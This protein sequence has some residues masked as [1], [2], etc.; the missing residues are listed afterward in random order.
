MATHWLR[1]INTTA[2]GGNGTPF[3]VKALAMFLR[4]V[5]GYTNQSQVIL[6]TGTGDSVSAPAGPDFQTLTDSFGSFLSTDVGKTITISG[7]VDPNNNG[8]FTIASYISATQITYQNAAGSAETSSF[9]WAITSTDEDYWTF[10]KSGSNGSINI[11]GSDKRFQDTT[12]A[13][14]VAGDDGK[15]ILIQDSTNSENSGWY[16]VTFVDASNVDLDFRSGAAEYPTQNLGANL[17]WWLMSDSYE[18]PLRPRCYWRLQTPHATGWEI[19]VLYDNPSTYQKLEIRL[20]PGAAWGGS[21]ILTTVHTGLPDGSAAWF[22]CAADDTGDFINFVFHNST[23]NYYGG[24][25]AGNLTEYEPDRAAVELVAL[26]GNSNSS[27]TAWGNSTTY[28]RGLIDGTNLTEGSIWENRLAKVQTCYMLEPSYYNSDLGLTKWTSGQI[29]QR[30][31]N[32]DF[33]EGQPIIID[34]D[35][36]QPIGEY[37][38]AGNLAGM[39]LMPNQATVRTAYDDVGTRDRFH[40]NDGVAIE[41]P[42]YTAQH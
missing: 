26:M 42:G 32:W 37:E 39:F 7:M 4:F 23:S 2:T 3:A 35:N 9:S 13:S 33:L 27:T 19:E 24:F 10:E 8:A 38:I 41:W 30:T 18:V 21:Q 15:W 5:C 6:N 17:S 1:E 11:T 40:I 25:V 22:Y 29:N 12:A 16:K 20:A 14:F 31:G 34:P 36:I 28:E